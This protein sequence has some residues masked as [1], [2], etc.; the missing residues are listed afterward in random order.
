[1]T[2]SEE[3]LTDAYPRQPT[4][5][6]LKTGVTC[7]GRLLARTGRVI[8]DCGAYAN[9]G[10]GTVAIAL[11]VLCGPY[12]TTHLNF[13]GVAVYTNK[14]A[15]GSFRAPAGP[16]ANFAV[17]SQMDIIADDLGIDPLE[18][19]L[20]NAFKEGDSGPAGE[21]LVSVSIAE[22][23][24]RAAEAIGWKDRHPAEG[25]G[26][27][28]ACSW[29]LTTR[30]ASGVD[31]KIGPDGKITLV[32]GAV[33]LGTGA[34]TGAAQV[35]AESSASTSPISSHQCRYGNITF[36]LWRAGQPHGLFGR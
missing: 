30:G 6:T 18:L 15:T 21:T 16:M 5:I 8:V 27:G 10:P 3:E 36:R 35:L 33:E 7:D 19:R 14:V 26:K 1:M 17:E 34:L 20:G 28:I 23:L 32:T 12:R 11:Q 2:T 31:V 9:S 29:W 24:T 4:I 22:C 13:E 25:R